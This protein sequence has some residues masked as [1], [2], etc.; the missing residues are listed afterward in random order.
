MNYLGTVRE[1]LLVYY[2][3][4]SFLS[5]FLSKVYYNKSLSLVRH[6][7]RKKLTRLSHVG[8]RKLDLDTNT[9]C[10]FQNI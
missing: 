1:T 9:K 3:K 10:Y 4:L 5:T 7:Q 8:F 6:H 2:T